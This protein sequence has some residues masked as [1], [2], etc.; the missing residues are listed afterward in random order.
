M[1]EAEQAAPPEAPPTMPETADLPAT[2]EEVFPGE[3]EMMADRMGSMDLGSTGA[4]TGYLSRPPLEEHA[5]KEAFE[6]FADP[7]QHLLEAARTSDMI[8]FLGLPV[9]DNLD[10]LITSV[11]EGEKT[12]GYSAARALCGLIY[13]KGPLLE[14]NPKLKQVGTRRAYMENGHITEDEAVLSFMR[15]LEE[16]KKKCEREG[17]YME[18]RTAA[19]RLHDLKLHEEQ[20][21]KVEMK[22]RHDSEHVDAQKA[23][24]MEQDQHNALWDAKLQEYEDSVQE[25]VTRL[26]EQH[27]AKLEKF[28]SDADVKTPKRPQFS[29][30]LLNQRKIQE[31]LAKQGKYE[32]AEAVKKMAD[33]MEAAEMEATQGTYA[34]GIA[35][36]EQQLRAVQ[37]QEMEALLHR[38]ARGRDELRATRS[39][40]LERR[41]QRFKNVMSELHNLQKL[42]HVQLEH[43][44]EQQTIAGKR[45]NVPASTE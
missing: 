14:S 21:R 15:A 7:G 28:Y 37:Q 35:L 33:K 17:K 41:Q 5:I 20:K 36:K 22:G 2:T 44:L 10:Q 3:T 11:A 43:F 30:Q 24:D 34:A 26:K 4:A 9:P 27:V 1:A 16:H 25:Q 45:H 38:A 23:F 42:E 32:E 40:D 29:K 13:G 12:I 6:K 8:Q 18:A 19:K 39:M 31:H